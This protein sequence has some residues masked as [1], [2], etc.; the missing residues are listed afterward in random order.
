V[1]GVLA[2][3]VL[4]LT[5]LAGAAQN[6]ASDAAIDA[7]IRASAEAAE[8]LQGPLDGAWTLVSAAGGA[9]FAF[10]IVDRPGGQGPLEG[11]WRDLRRAPTP[12][13]IGVIATLTR[14]SDTLTIGFV[15]KPGQP[16]I[17]IE[18]KS[19]ADGQWTGELREAGA[20]TAVSLRRG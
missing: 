9:I 10:Q 15:A 17:D 6:D 8:S 13:D 16:A 2:A 4:A 5:P 3:A 1:R 12:G 14:G 18:L 19:S 11:V 20:S 7:R